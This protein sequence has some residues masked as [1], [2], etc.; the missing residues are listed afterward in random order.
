MVQMFKA[1]DGKEY[2]VSDKIDLN[3]KDWPVILNNIVRFLQGAH[4][5][6]YTC[7]E[8]KPFETIDQVHGQT[9]HPDTCGCKF[10]QIFSHH[11]VINQI[12]SSGKIYADHKAG[13]LSEAERDRAIGKLKPVPVHP[14]R[15]KHACHRHKDHLETEGHRHHYRKVMEEHQTIKVGEYL[16]QAFREAGIKVQA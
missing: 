13:K 3:S 2:P 14:H 8:G 10:D 16:A 4:W 12:E 9:W 11:C 5:S 1:Y 6:E 7:S 15:T